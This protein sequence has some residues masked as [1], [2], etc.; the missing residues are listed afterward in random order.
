M[1]SHLGCLRKQL[2]QSSTEVQDQGSEHRMEAVSGEELLGDRTG[3]E[4][5]ARSQFPG[6]TH[7]ALLLLLP[8]LREKKER[9][10]QGHPPTHPPRSPRGGLSELAPYP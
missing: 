5:K 2:P 8:P 6:V 4:E 3:Q 1:L 7:P 9:R 10:G